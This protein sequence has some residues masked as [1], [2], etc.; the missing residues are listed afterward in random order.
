ME[1]KEALGKIKDALLA[2]TGVGKSTH[3]P[4]HPPTYSSQQE[5]EESIKSFTHP[6]THPTGGGKALAALVAFLGEHTKKF[7][8]GKIE[9]SPPTHVQ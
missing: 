4:T 6:P 3:P 8:V 2:H 9:E 1:R 5:E 7:K